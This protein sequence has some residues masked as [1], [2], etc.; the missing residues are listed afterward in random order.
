MKSTIITLA[1]ALTFTAA[2]TFAQSAEE[3]VKIIPTDK[4]GVLKLI[5]AQETSEPLQVTFL[6]E[7]NVIEKD[8]LKGN[9]PKGIMKRYDVSRISRNDFW[10]ELSNSRMTLT[11]RIMPTN[12]GKSFTPF[13]EKSSQTYLVSR[14]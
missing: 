13:L 5:Y 9:H 8:I 11:Y 10:I 7:K 3:S 1:A 4:S 2:A 12:N 14:R 6:S